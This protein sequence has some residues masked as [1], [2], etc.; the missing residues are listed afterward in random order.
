MA[1]IIRHA[2]LE[3]SRQRILII[4]G[5]GDYACDDSSLLCPVVST[6]AFRFLPSG[7]PIY[8]KAFP[9]EDGTGKPNKYRGP[10]RHGEFDNYY[11]WRE[12]F[13]STALA[14]DYYERLPKAAPILTS[15]GKD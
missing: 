8:L 5:R 6:S 13:R 12:Q 3:Y 10:Q 11:F 9:I 15:C 14:T 1:Y 2:D 7:V 4:L